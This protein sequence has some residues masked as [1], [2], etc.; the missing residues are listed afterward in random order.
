MINSVG[1]MNLETMLLGS[2]FIYFSVLYMHL[3]PNAWC[4]SALIHWVRFFGFLALY[5]PAVLHLCRLVV[6]DSTEKWC[7]PAPGCY[8]LG[9]LA[10]L[11]LLFWLSASVRKESPSIEVRQIFNVQCP[12]GFVNHIISGVELACLVWGLRVCHTVCKATSPPCQAWNIT[13]ALVNEAACSFLFHM[14]WRLLAPALHPDWMILI[15]FFYEHVTVTINLGLLLIP[16][17]G[18]MSRNSNY[19]KT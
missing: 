8:E 2:I 13:A 12:P 15:A 7:T 1:W 14:F 4:G 3:V 6:A 11:S 18:Q 16:K 9:T 19:R 17:V 5:G 10:S